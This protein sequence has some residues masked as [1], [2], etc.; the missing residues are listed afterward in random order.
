MVM[1]PGLGDD[2]QAIKGNYGNWDGNK[3]DRTVR[4]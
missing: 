3:S 4:M 2:I 1:V